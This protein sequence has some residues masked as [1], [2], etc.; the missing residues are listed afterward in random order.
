MTDTSEAFDPWGPIGG[1]L[2]GLNNSDAVLDVVGASGFKV[3]WRPMSVGEA[4]SHGTRVRAMRRDVDRAYAEATAEHQGRFA[5]AVVRELMRR[6]DAAALRDQLNQRLRPI[7]WGLSDDGQLE[8]EDAL[9]TERF[10][11]TN[12]EYDAYVAIREIL[13]RAE[14]DLVVADPYIGPMLFKTLRGLPKLPRQVRLLTAAKHLA[15]DFQ[16]EARRFGQ[17]FSGLHLEVRDASG[18]HDRFVVLDGRE[19]YHVGASL[20]D[21]GKRAFMIS[22]IEQADV[23][24]AVV[25]AVEQAWAASASIA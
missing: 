9:L 20:K 2:Y 21:A 8:T 12:S 6:P 7:G 13:G 3:D 11:P 16:E 4:Y 14:H 24:Q 10:F 19:A 18:F 23:A 17:Q 25:A 5:Q 15:G 1:V 22:R